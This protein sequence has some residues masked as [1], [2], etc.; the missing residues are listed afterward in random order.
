MDKTPSLSRAVI[1]LTLLIAA[2]AAG[3]LALRWGSNNENE[4]GLGQRGDEIRF[5]RSGGF[6]GQTT[7][8]LMEKDGTVRLLDT[9]EP[10]Q[11][12][13]PVDVAP[14]NVDRVFGAIQQSDWPDQE[15]IY[16]PGGCAD[17]Y[18]YDITYQGTH[19]RV[20]DPVPE[21]YAGVTRLLGRLADRL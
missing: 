9:S 20:F 4:S 19:V 3:Y 1:G 13:G 2:T 7:A 21:Q 5:V 8:V 18:R 10:G 16:P 14:R 11:K 12:T 15:E 6:A 17:C